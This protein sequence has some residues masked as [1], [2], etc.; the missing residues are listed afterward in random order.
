MGG[1]DKPSLYVGQSSLLDRVLRA[2]PQEARV[3][4]VG[5]RRLVAR[6]VLWTSEDPVG[7]GPV[8]ALE[9]GLALVRSDRV[10]LLAADLPFLDPATVDAVLAGLTRDGAVLADESG[11]DQY[12]CSAW[13]TGALRAADLSVPRLKDVVAQLR[14]DRL[15]VS[16]APGSPRPWEDCDTPSDLARAREIA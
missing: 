5:P 4:V 12:L 11:H 16:V 7:S 6:P 14:V 10:L 15:T 9:A 8:A 2:V 3:V 1:A 13:R